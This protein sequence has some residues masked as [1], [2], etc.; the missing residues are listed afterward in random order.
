MT[1]TPHTRPLWNFSEKLSILVS[2][3]VPKQGSQ[4][5]HDYW[6]GGPWLRPSLQSHWIHF[7]AQTGG[8]CMV[9]LLSGYNKCLSFWIRAGP[10]MTKAC[11]LIGSHIL[12]LH[13]NT[14]MCSGGVLCKV[15][16]KR[17][18]GSNCV[19]TDGA[20]ST[21]IAEQF[22]CCGKL[23]NLF[24]TNLLTLWS[25]NGA[26]GIWQDGQFLRVPVAVKSVATI[27]PEVSELVFRVAD[28]RK[29]E[30]LAQFK[31]KGWKPH[32]QNCP[33]PNLPR[34]VNLP[35]SFIYPFNGPILFDT[36]IA[37]FYCHMSK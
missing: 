17:V 31:G 5:G 37:I 22:Y 34:T 3:G 28:R 36:Y 14:T 21:S 35:L 1:P 11:I 9:K 18:V 4:F 30:S 2:M 23:E 29:P 24:S 13:L 32:S 10:P 8:H 15:C 27:V 16:A 25:G 6:L 20:F 7:T 26:I 12:H 33:V 19:Q